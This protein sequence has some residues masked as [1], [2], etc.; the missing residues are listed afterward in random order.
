[1]ID[2]LYQNRPVILT[3]MVIAF[4][5]AVS[6]L[7][8]TVLMAYKATINLVSIARPANSSGEMGSTKFLNPRFRMTGRFASSVA[9]I[10]PVEIKLIIHC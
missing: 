10:I 5:R 9:K 8:A 6:N 4:K 3:Q 2:R 7:P 1:M